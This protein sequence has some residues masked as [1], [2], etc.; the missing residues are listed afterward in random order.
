VAAVGKV[1]ALAGAVLSD[2]SAMPVCA[3]APPAL[4]C[5]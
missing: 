1:I 5:A 2:V 4:L 3:L